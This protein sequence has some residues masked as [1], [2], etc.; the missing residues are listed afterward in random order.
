MKQFN[1]AEYLANP[2]R[3]VITRDGRKVRIICTDFDNP[4]Y[5]VIAEIKGDKWPLSSAINGESIKGRQ[6]SCDLF[7]APIK[8]EGWV[9]ILN[10]PNGYFI[11]HT[12]IFKSKEEAEKVGK[13][14]GSYLTTIKIEWEE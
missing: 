8:Q 13:N 14:F 11:S 4:D 5:P 1:L 6:L 12:R 7:F 9:N 3:K 10:C 2:E